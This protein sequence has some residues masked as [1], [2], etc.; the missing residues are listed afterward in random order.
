V[1]WVEFPKEAEA[2]FLG[3]NGMRTIGAIQALEEALGKPVLTSNQVAF[4]QALRLAKISARVDGYGQ[5][6]G[7]QLP[8]GCRSLTSLDRSAGNVFRNLID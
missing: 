7:K 2:V 5:L 3:G 4:W 6:F 1:W 8:R